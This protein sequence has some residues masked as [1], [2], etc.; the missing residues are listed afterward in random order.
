MTSVAPRDTVV[1]VAA[2]AAS[3]VA[4]VRWLR[5]AQAEHYAPG[6]VS[7]FAARWWWVWQ[8]PNRVLLAAALAGLLGMA[9]TPAAGMVTTA[10][11]AT[12][13]FGLTLR[14]RTSKLVWTRRLRTL[15]GAWAFI[16][17]LIVAVGLSLGAGPVVAVLA[18]VAA[19]VLVDAALV[20][21]APLERRLAQPFVD[22]AAA[23]LRSIGP[24]VVAVTGSYGKTTT[25]VYIAHLL[26]GTKTVL[27]TPK[28][29]NN[30]NGL[31]RTINERLA[32]GTE[33]LVAEMGTYGP[34]EIAE[35][36]ELVPPD[37]SA[38]TAIGPV[39]L[40]RMGSE[41][42]ITAAK[43]EI[44]HHARA[45]VLN[46]DE[47]R[48]AALAD[49]AGADG[50]RVVRC[51]AENVAADVLVSP[52]GPL[53]LVVANGEEVARLPRLDAPPTN[54]A[55]AVAVAFLIGVPADEIA[56]R[57]ADL[58]VVDNRLSVGNT[59]SGATVIDDTFNSNPAGAA[60]A[61]EK[62]R[63]LAAP[64]G[65]RVVITPG[66]VELGPRQAPENEVLARAASSVATT[67]IVV[68][69]TNRPALVAGGRDGPAAVLCV[70]TRD[71]AVA[72]ARDH[73]GAGD[74]VLYENDLP[75]I[76]A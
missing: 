28:S 48:L 20:V 24:T 58:P 21:T 75:D 9:V 57:L 33:V 74:V 18:A 1:M 64:E 53:T 42:R 71:E 37:V 54:V 52:Q 43:A 17:V 31:A 27:A 62:L 15:A 26:A 47:P 22:A 41:E 55:I 23:R 36:C 7:R 56:T 68:G 30:R 72:W 10:T 29:Y 11:V 69:R 59:S 40:E 73:L 35:M 2:L 70:E 34:G 19:P 49:R 51:S 5:V 45:V 66:M 44:L 25:K 16:E 60:A 50:R 32:P 3:G 67:L 38:I 6:S 14:G 76:Y 4:A 12:G 65:Q 63:G 39:H 61:L 8:P 46:V 13:P